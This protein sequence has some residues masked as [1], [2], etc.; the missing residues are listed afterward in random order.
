M[1]VDEKNIDELQLSYPF[2]RASQVKSI[3]NIQIPS[4]RT[5]HQN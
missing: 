5:Q 3:L 4:F 2:M 1:N